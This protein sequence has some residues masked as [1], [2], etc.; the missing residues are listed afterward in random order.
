[1]ASIQSRITRQSNYK[2]YITYN[3]ENHQNNLWTDIDVRISSKH[4]SLVIANVFQISTKL[5]REIKV[6]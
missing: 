6:F 1:M 4:I 3:G 2:E 5:S